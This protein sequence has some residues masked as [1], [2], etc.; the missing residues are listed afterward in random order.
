MTHAADIGRLRWR[1]R[2]GMQE[3]DR[4]LAYWLDAHASLVEPHQL[5]AFERLLETEDDV[6]WAWM[7]GRGRPIDADLHR[8]VDEIRADYRA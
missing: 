6:L 1:A 8:L 3:L 7:T 4:L 5:A 2:R